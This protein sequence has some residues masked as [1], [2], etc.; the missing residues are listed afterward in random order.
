MKLRM[1][2]P[3]MTSSLFIKFFISFLVLLTLPVLTISIIMNAQIGRK[4]TQDMQVKIQTNM[5]N[6][7]EAT[8][9]ALDEAEKA[10]VLLMESER[11]KLLAQQ[12]PDMNAI[13]VDDVYLIQDAFDV[14]AN[15]S[16]GNKN[17]AKISIYN[18]ESEYVL[19]SEK[20]IETPQSNQN[21]EWIAAYRENPDMIQWIDSLFT[22]DMGMEI[23]TIAVIYPL[24]SYARLFSGAIAI[25][26]P[27]A[28]LNMYME[29][30]GSG[31]IMSDEGERVVTLND[32][33]LIDEKTNAQI[34]DA[35][36][37][38]V[39]RKGS[40]VFQMGSQ[41][42]LVSYTK[43][44][45]NNWY[46]V[47]IY[48]ERQVLSGINGFTRLILWVVILVLAAGMVLVYLMSRSLYSPVERIIRDIKK[49]SKLESQNRDEWKYIEDALREM[50]HQDKQLDELMRKQKESEK[51]MM[52]KQIVLDGVSQWSDYET[53]FPYQNY[54][55]ILA[56]PDHID[57]FHN[58]YSVEQCVYLLNLA[59][60]VTENL[61]NAQIGFQLQGFVKEEGL[62]LIL[63]SE[64]G[65]IEGCT[66]LLEA[67]HTEMEHV[68]G[69]SITLA[70]GAPAEAGNVSES[71]ESAR[72]TA[73]RRFFVGDGQI[74]LPYDSEQ[75]ENGQSLVEESTVFN[76]LSSGNTEEASV[77][78]DE[79]IAHFSVPK[80]QN[81][82]NAMQQCLMVLIS[83][84]RY[85]Q[86]KK[87]PTQA[88]LRGGENIYGDILKCKTVRKAGDYIYNICEQVMQYQKISG[89]K[90]GFIRKMMDYVHENYKTD[91]D[92]YAMAK[93][94]NIS[95][96]QLRR[97]FIEHTGQNIV[98]YTNRLRIQ[99][100]KRLLTGTE[101]TIMEISAELGYNNDQS[102]NRYFK[103]FEGMTPGE[104]RK[105]FWERGH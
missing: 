96:S 93:A 66:S 17:I 49:S 71:L 32:A 74:I 76:M 86:A 80:F 79:M 22:T 46:Y 28:R 83:I 75:I 59:R 39:A 7:M 61:V 43:S 72:R 34:T 31:Y 44:S 26:I 67:I 3:R 12:R 24:P 15:I 35:I 97:L 91:V 90:D 4:L 95:Y 94:L 56:E 104:Y 29:E 50:E 100:A 78:I 52:L 23:P 101:K 47:S 54:S 21:T 33:C 5:S 89:V 30:G 10:S 58:K 41:S 63:N 88:V 37:A 105:L 1:I 53:L 82:E 99:E 48:N 14:L 102:F 2:N 60:Q 11:L 87:I 69:V 84:S 77:L 25:H 55:V 36:C 40:F 45:Y 103:K 9:N 81:Y 51:T 92:V 38:R 70:V 27:V 64:V 65:N 98:T 62:I 16:D 8:E 18:Q 85:M 19:T 42:Y 6:V 57:V 68:F 20:R 13:Q 73:E